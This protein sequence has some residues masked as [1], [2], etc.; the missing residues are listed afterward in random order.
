MN[1]NPWANAGGFAV[2]YPDARCDQDFSAWWKTHQTIARRVDALSEYAKALPDT[3][4]DWIARQ[5]A[6]ETPTTTTST[7]AECA[8]GFLTFTAANR[9]KYREDDSSMLAAFAATSPQC[10][11]WITARLAEVHQRNYATT[12]DI[13]DS[14]AECQTLWDR[15]VTTLPAPWNE[16][17]T[18][19]Q[20]TARAAFRLDHPGCA[21]W[22]DRQTPRASRPATGGGGGGLL[23]IAGI[24][25]AAAL[26][27]GKKGF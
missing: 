23:L 8:A 3:C 11:A 18:L 26:L 14:D 15:Y 27:G 24:V 9:E 12:F 19:M 22:I 10:A 6:I 25:A 5:R 1:L 16:L 17:S 13:T 2:N 20:E 4:P 7:D 21:A